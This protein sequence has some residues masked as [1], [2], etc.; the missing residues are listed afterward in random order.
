MKLYSLIGD[1]YAI[2][3]WKSALGIWEEGKKGVKE[4][5]FGVKGRKACVWECGK[6]NG[7]MEGLSLFDLGTLELGNFNGGFWRLGNLI[8]PSPLCD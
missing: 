5:I 4:G 6:D 2:K 7:V 1:N 3:W 8:W